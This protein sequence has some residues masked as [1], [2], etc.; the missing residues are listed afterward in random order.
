MSRNTLVRS[1]ILVMILTASAGILLAHSSNHGG[2]TVFQT[3]LGPYE[4][5]HASLA[6]DSLDG[7]AQNAE[8]IRATAREAAASFDADRAAVPQEKAGQCKAL[9]PKIEAAAARLAKAT[10]LEEARTAFG[11]L[12]RPMVQWREMS[13]ATAKPKV[14]YCPMVKKPWLQESDQVANPYFGSKMLKCG[15]IVSN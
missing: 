9:L 3:V 12:S 5:I 1:A 14:V 6:S 10:T 4:A 2:S 15:N 13:S 7:V 8:K 11:E